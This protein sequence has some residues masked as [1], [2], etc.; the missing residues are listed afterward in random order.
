MSATTREEFKKV[1][2]R[3]LG[4]PTLKINVDDDAV[5][6]C[7]DMALKYF[8]DYHFDGSEKT[9][10]KH[11]L[12][13]A[14]FP[15]SVHHVNVW[16]GGTGYN[17]ADVVV[18]SG[19]TGNG[20]AASLTTDANGSIVSI[21]MSDHG[22][23]YVIAPTVTITT[24]GGTGADLEAE[25]GG[26]IEM[27]DNITGVHRIFDLSSALSS[28]NLFNIQYQFVLNEL[29]TFSSTYS[30]IPY[31][32]TLQYI[33]LIQQL[34]VG[35]QPIRYNRH[36]NRLYVDMNWDRIMVDEYLIVEAQ[37]MLDPDKF[38]DV[39]GDRWLTEYTTEKIKK[40]WGAVMKKY[41]GIQMLGGTL[42]TGQKMYDEA[43]NRIDKLE[44]EMITKY[45][46]PPQFEIG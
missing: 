35:Q 36:R 25:L 11:R 34:L 4:W 18:F 26:F 24:S 32:V 38:P 10:Y 15:K 14:N 20:A 21:N 23:D 33:S 37:E 5:Q 40:I 19:A 2:F 16:T 12:T 46:L 7:I 43:Q 44:A 13:Q 17:N 9:Y 22:D 30:M 41:D 45:S 39:W 8:A 29:Y 1:C 3:Q 42:F 27:P 28:S 6:D 31:Y